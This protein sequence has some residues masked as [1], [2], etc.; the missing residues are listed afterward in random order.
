MDPLSDVLRKAR[1]RSGVFLEAEFY[2]P[3]CILSQLD[4][5][6]CAGLIGDAPHMML[7]HYVIEGVARVTLDP[8][9][10]PEGVRPGGGPTDSVRPDGVRPVAG[11]GGGVLEIGPGELVLFP[12]NDRHRLGSHLDRTPVDSKDVVIA[13]IDGGLY[14]IRHGGEVAVDGPGGDG[15]E[16]PAGPCTRMICGF[17]GCDAVAGN[18]VIDALPPVLR[19]PAAP[20][21]TE[22][23]RSTFEYAAREVWAGRPG[24]AS[25][26]AKLSELL[27]V[28]AVRRY[29]ETLPPERTGWLAGLR[30]PHVAR[31]LALLHDDAA[32][33]WT[34][35]RLGRAV[36]LS[37]S[38]LAERFGRLVGMAPMHYLTAWRMQLAAQSLRDTDACLALIAREVGYESEASFSRAFKKAFGAAP[39]TWR[40]QAA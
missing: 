33:P 12:R 2:E 39:A 11:V 30:D 22:W 24:S 3:W 10:S 23:I 40:R 27:F 25:V 5:K 37:R 8:A 29:V 21:G 19:V 15:S 18:P 4:V 6:Y 17:L 7:Y 38:A 14:T 32:H 13:P 9:G 36:G 34:V 31:A 20:G 28:E 16:P 35:D 26:L 1:L